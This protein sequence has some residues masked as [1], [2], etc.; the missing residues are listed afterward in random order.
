VEN[1]ANLFLYGSHPLSFDEKFRLS[2]PLE[3]RDTLNA[4]RD[5]SGFFVV[6]GMNL[7]LWLWPD[8]VYRSM[9]ARR[10]SEIAPSVETHEL[11]LL[12]FGMA[13]RQEMD[14]QNRIRIPEYRVKEA[15]LGKEVT[16]VGVCDHL[17]VYDRRE[18]EV[19]SKILRARGSEI[20]LRAKQ[21]E[22]QQKA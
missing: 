10:N 9:V 16:I 1:S 6:N 21:V 2:M 22:T 14:K 19:Y 5:G 8:K 13:D 7:K 11:D 4:E 3:I 12:N 17:E 15:S 18:W 20:A